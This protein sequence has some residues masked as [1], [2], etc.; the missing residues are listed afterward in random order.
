LVEARGRALDRVGEFAHVAWPRT[1]EQ[2]GHG[3][4]HDADHW[5]NMRDIRVEQ[6]DEMAS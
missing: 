3:I 1:P 2:G 6:P 4:L 5:D